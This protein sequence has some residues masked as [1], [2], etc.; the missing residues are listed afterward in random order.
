M[1]CD[2]C[3]GEILTKSNQLYHYRESG[4]DNVYIVGITIEE[5]QKCGGITLDT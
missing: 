2:L 3:Q 4:L 1:N 5:C